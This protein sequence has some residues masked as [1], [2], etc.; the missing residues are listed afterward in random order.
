M[1]AHG[2]DKNGLSWSNGQLDYEKL[3]ATISEA[4]SGYP[5]LY[6]YGL[7]KARFLTELLAQPV[8]YLEDFKCPAPRGLKSQYS[9][10]HALPQ[11]LSKL[12]M[13]NTKRSNTIQIAQTS[14]SL[15]RL[16]QLSTRLYTP[17]RLI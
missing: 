5:H 15:P 10:Q 16:Y 2:S 11:K 6:A 4:V 8:L 12:Q 9:L 3:R 13:R 17:Y 7:A 14:P 1:T